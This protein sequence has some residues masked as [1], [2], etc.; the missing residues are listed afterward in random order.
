MRAL[1]FA[2]AAAGLLT[3]CVVVHARLPEDLVD[4]IRVEL[5]DIQ[6]GVVCLHDSHASSPGSAVCMDGVLMRCSPAGQWEEE[7]SC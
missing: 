6:L 7:G 3:G 2:L 5:H 4:D 1:A